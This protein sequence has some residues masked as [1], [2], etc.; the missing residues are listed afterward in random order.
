M[1]IILNAIAFSACLV[2]FH[3]I[4]NATERKPL[5]PVVLVYLG[6][7]ILSFFIALAVQHDFPDGIVH[8]LSSAVSI[9]VFWAW[10]T[11]IILMKHVKSGQTSFLFIVPIFILLLV[12]NLTLKI[13]G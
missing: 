13:G 3:R 1:A 8:L 10:T 9:L 5:F 12:T 2:W 6:S 7:V 11:V 4:M